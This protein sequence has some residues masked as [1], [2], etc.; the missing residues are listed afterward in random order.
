MKR[1]C[2]FNEFNLPLQNPRQ[3]AYSEI[4]I[5][6]TYH[7]VICKPWSDRSG[8]QYFEGFCKPHDTKLR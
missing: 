5:E 3:N 2:V 8:A 6:K 1:I 4:T 7:R